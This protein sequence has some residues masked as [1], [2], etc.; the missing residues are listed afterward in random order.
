MSTQ[1]AFDPS[2]FE[3]FLH[4]FVG[5]LGATVNA[6]LVLIGARLGL[7]RA[8]AASA[9]P[10][11]AAEL[12]KRTNTA[13]RYVREWLSAQAAS[14]Y[15]TY[16]ADTDRFSLTPEQAFALT[17][18]DGIAYFPGAFQLAVGSLSA[19]DEIE[20]CFKTGRGFGWHEHDANVFEGCERFFRPNYLAS[21]LP[22]WLPALDG[23]MQRLER[24]A[25]VADVGCGHGASTVLMATAFPNS[26]FHGFDYHEGSLEAARERAKDAG[27]GGRV[28]FQ[29]ASAGDFPGQ[30]YDLIAFFD[31]LHDMGD[32]VGAAAHVRRALAP[33]G[34]WMIVE[35]MA[36]DRLADNLNP[37]GRAYYGFSTLLCTPNSLSQEVGTALGA[38]A[39]EARLRRVATDGGFTRVKRVGETPFNMVLEARP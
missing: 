15:V 4:R 8:L 19:V 38:Q 16:H 24:G 35:P 11:T 21:L 18:P 6:G 29:R 27:L 32:P 20:N 10:L 34:V 28:S 26:T 14:E 5:D 9:T 39:G 1:A 30:G 33:D 36:A 3:P 7:Y 23:M 2:K 17:N 22:S 12:A 31:S 13:E 25:R 37:V